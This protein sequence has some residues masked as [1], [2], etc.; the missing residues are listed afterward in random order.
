MASFPVNSLLQK[1]E[2]QFPV[3]SL[4]I[5]S[6]DFKEFT[7]GASSSA[8][9]IEGASKQHGRGDSIWD[10]FAHEKGLVKDK[11]K[12]H[13][14]IRHCDYWKDDIK[15][16]KKMGLHAYR[17][18]ISWSRIISKGNKGDPPNE[19]GIKFYSDLIDELKANKIEP[20]VTL[21]HWDLP[22]VLEEKYGGFRNPQI[23]EDFAYYA[24][25]CFKNFGNR[26]KHWITLNEPWT[27]S[28][29]GY[30]VGLFAPGRGF[31][32]GK[33]TEDL[34]PPS[35]CRG[36]LTGSC[37]SD[38][39]HMKG[40]PATEPYIVTHN[41]LLAH[42]AAV[43]LYRKDY[44]EK[45]GGII[46]ISLVSVWTIPLNPDEK[47]DRKAAERAIDYMFGW[48]MDPLKFGRYPEVMTKKVGSRLPRFTDEQAKMVK[49]SY[50][51]I[52]LNYYTTYYILNAPNRDQ[53]LQWYTT[54]PL[55]AYSATRGD[56][57]IG[58]AGSPWLYVY[59]EG[60]KELLLYIK[61]KYDNPLIYITENGFVDKDDPTQSLEKA[62]DD[63]DRI[64]YIHDHLLRLKEAIDES[65]ANV[66]GYFA[67]SIMDNFEWGE[68]FEMRFGLY[69]VDYKDGLFTRHPKLSAKW[70]THFLEEKD[71]K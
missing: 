24:G 39:N 67:W 36:A 18:S 57:P 70:Y 41:Q 63:P 69:Y 3:D 30:A 33:Q 21:F 17:F 20:Y 16:M 4:Q 64:M 32:L 48:F 19:E 53:H 9:Q 65:K 14:A 29:G 6:S 42:A 31:D 44:K 50:D 5:H 35:R 55:F 34:I 43:K 58:K 54:D 45:Q 38:S 27:F 12:G 71:V 1:N 11:E 49:G 59:P 51:F 13:E 26:V 10:A 28:Y 22:L 68:G 40:D 23:I 25:I 15:L 62:L 37:E 52:G 2:K 46:G 8:F 61:D 56:K 7:F 60:L 66:K 47:K